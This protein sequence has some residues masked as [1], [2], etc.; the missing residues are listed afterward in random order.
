MLTLPRN[1]QTD[2]A[3]AELAKAEQYSKDAKNQTLQKINEADRKIEDGASKAKSG[4][5]SWFGGK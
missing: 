3:R 4:I 2:K 5:S 1:Q